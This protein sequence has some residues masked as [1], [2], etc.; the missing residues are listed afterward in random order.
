MNTEKAK[1]VRDLLEDITSLDILLGDWERNDMIKIMKDLDKY[2]KGPFYAHNFYQDAREIL[3]KHRN[4]L[5]EE[6]CDIRNR[7]DDRLLNEY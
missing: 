2:S 4:Q 6:L 7:L 3:K 5:G 1:E